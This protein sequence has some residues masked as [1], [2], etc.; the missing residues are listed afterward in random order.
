MSLHDV[1][2]RLLSFSVGSLSLGS[3]LAPS[4]SSL[5]SVRSSTLSIRTTSS[6]ES[7]S[8]FANPQPLTANLTHQSTSETRS[9]SNTAIQP[10]SSANVQQAADLTTSLPAADMTEQQNREGIQPESATDQSV[11]Y[12]EQ[13]QDSNT[14]ANSHVRQLLSTAAQSSGDRSPI[15]LLQNGRSQQGDPPLLL[16]MARIQRRNRSMPSLSS[17]ADQQTLLHTHHPTDYSATL[18]IKYKSDEV[19]SENTFLF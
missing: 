14:P 13:A 2:G 17:T 4:L 1:N 9:V 5:T 6:T 10:S 15:S 3:V 8:S 7:R 16:N 18:L 19:L 12:A 11:T